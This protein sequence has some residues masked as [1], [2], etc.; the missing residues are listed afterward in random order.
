MKKRV[1][2]LFSGRG[3]LLGAVQD[4]LKK[5]S[6]ELTLVITNNPKVDSSQ[7]P[8]S[9]GC[10]FTC[11]DHQNYKSRRDHE[12]E[13]SSLIDRYQIDLIVLGGYRRIFSTEF[14]ERY[15]HKTINTHPSL[16]PAF[17]GDK[18]QLKAIQKGVRITGAT[19]HFINNEVDQGPIITQAAVEVKPH[20]T[21]SD[22]REA[23][24]DVEKLALA[25]A[26]HLFLEDKLEIKDDVVYVKSGHESELFV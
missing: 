2:F 14:V 21:E 18:A 16:L 23:I 25:R 15:G 8:I 26:V 24:I 11:I 5:L 3:S 7:L 13:I 20:Y 12:N 19:V 9:E 6:S 1:A 17:V 4:G 10:Y 22:L